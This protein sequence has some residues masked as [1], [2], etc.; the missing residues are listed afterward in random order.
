L[1]S[2]QRSVGLGRA[3][4]THWK[5]RASRTGANLR[6]EQ[7]VASGCSSRPS[8]RI[9]CTISGCGAPSQ[10][11]GAVARKGAAATQ[12]T[13]PS[14]D[15]RRQGAEGESEDA[16]KQAPG[17][18]QHPAAA[19]AK[20]GAQHC[21]HGAGSVAGPK[22]NC[23]IRQGWRSKKEA[24]IGLSVIRPPLPSRPRP[25]SPLTP[26]PARPI[27]CRSQRRNTIPAR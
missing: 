19:G 24:L 8:A 12:P 1:W 11:V 20:R 16:S 14:A 6:A 15:N 23:D 22:K 21:L 25:P 26:P 2:D 13:Q 10:M 3:S 18:D 5:P 7:R 4:G 9:A 27:L 17:G